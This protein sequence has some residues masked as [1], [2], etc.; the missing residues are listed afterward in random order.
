MD[1]AHESQRGYFA[2][3]LYKQMKANPD[4]FLLV[5]DLGYKVFDAHFKDFPD[6]CINCGASEQGMLG[7]AV[8]LA[9]KGKIPFCYS[10]TSFLLWRPAETIKLYLNE[11]MWPVKLV[12]SGRDQDYAHDGPSH[13][14]T[15]AKK[16]LDTWPNIETFWPGSKEQAGEAVSQ[17]IK[18]GTPNFI[19]LRR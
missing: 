5:G 2:F 17:M 3:E 19:S 7:I 10:I 6:R 16:L 8:G 13:D 1:K 9:M 11:E 15:E 14:A 12:G 4:I 18:S